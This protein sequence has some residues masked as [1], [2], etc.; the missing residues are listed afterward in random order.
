MVGEDDETDGNRMN[1][2]HFLGHVHGHGDPVNCR[3]RRS[4]TLDTISLP[5]RL[6]N[7]TPLPPHA[8]IPPSTSSGMKWSRRTTRSGS[9]PGRAGE[10]DR[11]ELATRMA[12]RD[13]DRLQPLPPPTAAAHLHFLSIRRR[14]RPAK[15][16]EAYMAASRLVIWC[17]K[18]RRRPGNILAYASPSK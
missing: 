5:R 12:G 6:L 15:Q 17:C 3:L 14:R 11:P 16:P 2:A 7:L 4:G 10:G 1:C 8:P 18:R 9:T 13:P